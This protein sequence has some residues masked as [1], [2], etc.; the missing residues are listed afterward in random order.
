MKLKTIIFFCLTVFSTC[1]SQQKEVT[2]ISTSNFTTNDLNQLRQFESLLYG[3]KNKKQSDYKIV[4]SN[5]LGEVIFIKEAEYTNSIDLIK[6]ENGLY[7]L[8]I[9]DNNCTLFTSQKLSSDAHNIAL[10]LNFS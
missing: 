5:I 4:I 7:F 6:F 2:I 1:Y 9:L 10:N 3:N 8:K